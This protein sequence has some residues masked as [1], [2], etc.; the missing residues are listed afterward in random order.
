MYE[1]SQLQPVIYA[2]GWTLIH[3]LWQGL[4][5]AGTFW[6]FCRL[7]RAENALLRYWAGMLAF[8]ATAVIPAATFI[9]Y[10]ETTLETVVGPD[11]AMPL[12]PVVAGMSLSL[13]QVLRASMEPVLPVVVVLWAVG[14]AFLSFRAM[15][16]WIG[17]RR[18]VSHGTGEVGGRLRATALRLAA[19]L[20]VN[21]VVRVLKTARIT[22]PTVVG[23]LKPVI[24]LPVAVITR[25][26][27]D[28][29]EMIIA[30]ELGHIRRYDYLF[31]LFQ[32]VIET[33]FF[34]HPAVRWMSAQVRQER[35]HCCDDLVV[36]QCGRPVLYARALANLE[37]LRRPVPALT[38]SAAGGDLVQRVRRIVQRERP[39][40][41][42]G[43]AQ[44]ALML[45]LAALVSVS[46]TQG[47]D[48][49]RQLMENTVAGNTIV[50]VEDRHLTANRSGWVQGMSAYS[51]LMAKRATERA[52]EV[53]TAGQEKH[54]SDAVSMDLA[55]SVAPGPAGPEVEKPL[56]VSQPEA[57]VSSVQPDEQELNITAMPAVTGQA[58]SESILLASAFHSEKSMDNPLV[59]AEAL[60][61]QVEQQFIISPEV[62]VAPIYPFKA[63]RK[64]LEGFV[65]LGFSV[66]AKGRAENIQVVDSEPSDIF[67]KS[68]ISALQK[69]V[70]NID[71]GYSGSARLYQLF[72]FD[73]EDDGLILKKRERRCE[74]TGSRICGL[75]RY[76]SKD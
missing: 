64:R 36:A 32:M 10:W 15:L 59:R 20:G 61:R 75:K 33:L 60:Q 58:R 68:A 4:G 39:G 47:L 30:H 8:L 74:I 11:L 67:E 57:I 73:M 5:I 72:E 62:V 28:Q 1:L 41:H 9:Y 51:N 19:Q 52:F 48:I 12:V 55:L 31:N 42:S 50:I 53:T 2:L 44:L 17:A 46:A 13:M 22:V 54:T 14:V 38:L 69:W 6:L 26:P 49:Q 43:F 37:V 25:L 24:L 63:R 66:D 18:L 76:N 70:F 34:Y 7:T 35:E 71:P 45:G 21:Q 3:F 27:N 40:N 56:N 29:L 65:R 16:G 23:W